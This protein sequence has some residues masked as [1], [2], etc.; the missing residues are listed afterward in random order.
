MSFKNQENKNYYNPVRRAI[1]NYEM[2]LP[3]EKVA[4]GMSGGKDSIS[5]FTLLD[6]IAKPIPL[7]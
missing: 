4:V 2:I 3:H 5:L 1:L 7:K 6:T